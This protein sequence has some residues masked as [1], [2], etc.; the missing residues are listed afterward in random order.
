MATS[1]YTTNLHLSAW[2]ESDRPKRADFV[3]D[4][5]IIDRELGGHLADDTVHLTAAEKQKI[6]EPY[7]CI[8]YAGSGESTRTLTVGFTPKIAI[9]YKRGVPPVTV[10]SGVTVVNSAAAYYGH[11]G[12]AGIAI[13]SQ[14][15]AVQQA[16]SATDGVR[17]NLNESG[18]QYALIAFR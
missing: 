15:V 9:V 12:S 10:S 18:S 1:R 14:G 13:S 11:G 3:S 6:D 2:E 5:E 16:S 8:A 7:V 4:N 17:N